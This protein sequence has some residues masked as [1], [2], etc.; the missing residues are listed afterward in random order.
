MAGMGVMSPS[1]PATPTQHRGVSGVPAGLKSTFSKLFG[2]T[3]GDSNSPESGGGL[4]AAFR[5]MMPKN[6]SLSGSSSSD[7]TPMGSGFSGYDSPM[8]PLSQANSYN[9]LPPPSPGRRSTLLAVCPQLPPSMQR[10]E[11]CLDDYSVNDTDLLYK[12]YASRGKWR[13][14]LITRRGR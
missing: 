8:S 9:P 5:A 14:C 1:T 10:R 3:W 13:W 11:W 2:S 6:G 12:G 4:I 7:L